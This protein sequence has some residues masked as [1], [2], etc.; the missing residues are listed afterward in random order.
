[1]SLRDH[2]QAGWR[3]IFSSLSTGH[4]HR[5]ADQ[6]ERGTLHLSLWNRGNCSARR[7]PSTPRE[8]HGPLNP[9]RP[10][11]PAA[12]SGSPCSAMRSACSILAS[13]ARSQS[14]SQG[15]PAG[16]GPQSI[17]VGPDGKLWFTEL[18]GGRSGG[19]TRRT[20][21]RTSRT[22]ALLRGCPPAP[23]RSAS[24]RGRTARAIRSS[25]SPTR[26]TTLSAMIN[27]SR[28]HPRDPGTQQTLVGFSRSTR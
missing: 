1:M 13:P 7:S 14:Y 4:A 2:T 10:S 9:P 18:S 8:R 16:S 23:G 19:S 24:R 21:P 11:P 27:P 12:S 5:P 26:T 17:T 22:T 25:G 3:R 20:R 15:L 28:H 6:P